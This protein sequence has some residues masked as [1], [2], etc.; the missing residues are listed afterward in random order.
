MAGQRKAKVAELI[1]EEVARLLTAEVHDG[2]LGFVTVT[3]VTMSGDLRYARIQV[4]VLE[5]GSRR[6]EIMQKLE[7]EKGAIRRQ[8]AQALRLRYTPE[9]S[10]HLD[11]SLETSA[12]IERILSDLQSSSHREGS[13]GEDEEKS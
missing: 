4:S 10:F 12:R 9:I 3:G 5:E 7:A 6:A 11:T 13:Q 8:L 1:Q 2:R